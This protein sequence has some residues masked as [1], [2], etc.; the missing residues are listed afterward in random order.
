M[1]CT[2][3]NICILTSCYYIFRVQIF[4]KDQPERMGTWDIVIWEK[5]NAVGYVPSSWAVDET[6]TTYLWPKVPRQKLQKLIDNCDDPDANINYMECNATYKGTVTNLAMA[7]RKT[8][9]LMYTSN[10]DDTESESSNEKVRSA[11]VTSQLMKNV[12]VVEKEPLDNRYGSEKSVESVSPSPSFQVEAIPL[13]GGA[14]ESSTTVHTI[15]KAV[16]AIKFDITEINKK[17]GNILAEVKN[18]HVTHNIPSL[19]LDKFKVPI[20][21][22]HELEDLNGK[23]NDAGLFNELAKI[24][25]L[26]GGLT[27]RKNVHS[28]IKRLLEKNLAVLYSAKGKK[29]KKNLSTLIKILEAIYV[30]VRVNYPNATEQEILSNISSALAGAADWEGGRK[31]RAPEDKSEKS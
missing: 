9:M 26:V 18:I 4:T 2:E 22:V 30:A 19:Q 3:V 21:S 17:I 7:K 12:Y 5:E 20:G 29:G 24:L 15:L 11:H 16:A 28:I 23:L 6:N 25:S 1:C 8:N 10:V 14:N 31:S 27:L 13:D